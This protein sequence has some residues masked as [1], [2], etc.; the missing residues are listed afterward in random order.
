[1]CN[2][3]WVNYPL[4]IKL[5]IMEMNKIKLNPVL[6]IIA[7]SAL[8]YSCK[9]K[10]EVGKPGLSVPVVPYE[11]Q[12]VKFIFYDTYP[13]TVVATDEVQLRSEVSGFITGIYYREG[14]QVTRGAKL[15][16]IDRRKYQAAFEEAKAAVEIADANLSKAD[17]DADRYKKL[18][19]QNAIAKQVLDDALTARENAQLQLRSAKARLS[20]AETDFN[21]SLITAPFSGSIGFSL[22]KPGAFV[23]SGQ[24]L[25]NTISS[26][27]PV[28]IDFTLDEKSLS[29]ILQLQNKE[30]VL[31]DSTFR[32]V[33]SDNSEYQYSGKLDIIDRAVD[34]ETGTIKVRTIFPN[35]ERLLRPGMNCKIKIL[36]NNS[37]MVISIPVRAVA[38]Q[39]SEYFVY[40]I[41]NNNVVKQKRIDLG[42]IHGENAIIK[43]GLTPG[44]KIVLEGIQKVHEGSIVVLTDSNK[45]N[46]DQGKINKSEK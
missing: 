46:S 38:E 20:N 34:P 36:N 18:D 8:L 16:E 25:L 5:L 3:P 30:T 29:S 6:I 1:M 15:Y 4:P 14:S 41:D 12:T 33:L 19:E 13:G 42:P 28:G 2:R 40:L 26:D 44:D 43:K 10:T 35:P 31:K 23:T 32:L 11:V 27:D 21:Y 37:G 7:V 17:R 45:G 22:V 39:M 9:T 24:T